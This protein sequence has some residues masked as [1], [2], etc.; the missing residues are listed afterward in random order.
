MLGAVLP[1]FPQKIT[2]TTANDLRLKRSGMSRIGGHH[3]S[4]LV[5]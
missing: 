3:G 4:P 2:S 1:V 5:E